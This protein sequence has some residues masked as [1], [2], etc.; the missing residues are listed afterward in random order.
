MLRSQALEILKRMMPLT[1]PDVLNPDAGRHDGP[2]DE[3]AFAAEQVGYYF[4]YQNAGF[5]FSA[6]WPDPSLLGLGDLPK[7]ANGVAEPSSGTPERCSSPMAR[8]RQKAVEYLHDALQDEQMWRS[9]ITGNPDEGTIPV[10]QLPILQSVWAEWASAPPDFMLPTRGPTSV[11]DSLGRTPARLPRTI[12]GVMQFDAARPE[13]IKYLSGE[14][15]TP[16]WPA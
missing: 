6:N 13:W 12:L 14:E 5:Q 10:G 11:F 15:R 9:Q 4:K 2:P 3:Q 1:I 16:R 8:T 7:T